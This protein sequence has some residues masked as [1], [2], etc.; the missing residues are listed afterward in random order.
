MTTQDGRGFG[1]RDTVRLANRHDAI[2]AGALGSV[3]GWFVGEPRTY[4]VNFA[5]GAPRVAEVHP[6]EIFLAELD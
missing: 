6:D 2:P 1:L 5:A 3:L 4:V